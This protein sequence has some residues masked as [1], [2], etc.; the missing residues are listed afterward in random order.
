MWTAFQ[1]QEGVLVKTEKGEHRLSLWVVLYPFQVTL[2]PL[3]RPLVLSPLLPLSHCPTSSPS[4]SLHSGFCDLCLPR[5]FVLGE[6]YI[7]DGRGLECWAWRDRVKPEDHL[8]CLLSVGEG[9]TVGI[10]TPTEA[11][12]DTEHRLWVGQWQGI[13]KSLVAPL[14]GQGTQI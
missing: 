10:Q 14:L 8:S 5:P 6:G 4:P 3:C 12:I 7:K 13:V 1:T 2:P 11:V 9:F